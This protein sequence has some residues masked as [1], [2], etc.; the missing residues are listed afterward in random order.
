MVTLQET[1]PIPKSST[2]NKS[3]LSKTINECQSLNK[4]GN[5]LLSDAKTDYSL[6]LTRT[7]DLCP[8]LTFQTFSSTLDVPIHSS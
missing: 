3:K 5:N 1:N 6:I 8:G 7:L 4:P 2:E